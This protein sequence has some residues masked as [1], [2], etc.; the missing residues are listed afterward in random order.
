[1]KKR[2]KFGEFCFDLVYPDELVLPKDFALFEV[3]DDKVDYHYTLVISDILPTPN[4]KIIAKRQ[5]MTVFNTDGLEGRV[6]GIRGSDEKYACYEEIAS[7]EAKITFCTP[8][9]DS[10][11]PAPLFT[12]MLAPERRMIAYDSLIFHCAHLRHNGEAILFSGPSGIGKSTQADLWVKYQ[13]SEV[14]NGD[15]ALL[16]KVDGRWSANGWPVCGSSGICKNSSTPIKAI[17]MLEQASQNKIR[18]LS[19]F[20][21]V[22]LLYEQTT[23]NSWNVPA[24]ERSMDLLEMMANEIPIYL[25]SCTIS[26]EAV[27]MLKQE[28]DNK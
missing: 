16:S 22:T 2:L 17:V 11:M 13:N 10:V 28:I 7:D 6:M 3:L 23:V 27:L 4:G 14:I 20:E 5:D 12:S 21:A 25:L 18:R 9:L 15:R 1:M 8:S 24:I 26:E 19:V